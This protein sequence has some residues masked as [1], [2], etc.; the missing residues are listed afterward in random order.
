V[1]IYK[2]K[3]YSPKIYIGDRVSFSGGV[4]ITAIHQITI[5]NDVLF[6]SNIYIS[7]HNHG[8]YSNNV[9]SIPSEPPSARALI[10]GGE[11]FIGNNVWV[12]DNVN[13]VAPVK[14][15][16]GSIIGANSVVRGDIPSN[17]IVA[18]SP[19]RIIKIFNEST[20][21]WIPQK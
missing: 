1:V 20:K 10:S 21:L 11:V 8:G 5:G 9:H 17:A 16:D 14:I 7:D 3:K 2:G 6:G 4:H 18:G 13:I 15:G 19:A 12:G